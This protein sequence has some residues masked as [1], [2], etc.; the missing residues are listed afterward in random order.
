MRDYE[1]TYIISGSLTE[2][3]ASKVTD[4]VNGVITSHSGKV[5]SEDVWGRKR[6]AYEIE[7]QGFGWYVVTRFSLAGE[8]IAE[9]ERALRLNAKVIRSLI[10]RAEEVPS[11]EEVAKAT[12][13]AAA[14][15]E[16]EKKEREKAEK[17]APVV[18]EE[19]ESEKPAKKE[20]AAERK[21][22]QAEVEEKL[23]KLLNEEE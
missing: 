21:K 2:D 14:A 3:E 11:E 16:A 15:D 5:A 8:H 1:I 17:P 9:L 23:G 6:L 4:D 13:A 10:V 20:T 12:K 7:K 22:R 18:E 19:P